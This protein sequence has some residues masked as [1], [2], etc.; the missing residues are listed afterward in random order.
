MKRIEMLLI[1]IGFFACISFPSWWFWGREPY[2]LIEDRSDPGMSYYTPK[3]NGWDRLY[4]KWVSP[5]PQEIKEIYGDVE[6][7]WYVCHNYLTVPKKD[8]PPVD[9]DKLK[10]IEGMTQQI[11]ELAKYYKSECVPMGWRLPER[12]D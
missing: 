6:G 5:P 2:V 4:L 9:L 10:S 1:L 3:W 7:F 12:Q 8:L 11:V